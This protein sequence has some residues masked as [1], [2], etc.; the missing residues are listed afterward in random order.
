MEAPVLQ[1]CLRD[2]HGMG[3][4]LALLEFRTEVTTATCSPMASFAMFEVNPWDR[5]N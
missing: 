2:L 1:K 3:L 4:G 5:G